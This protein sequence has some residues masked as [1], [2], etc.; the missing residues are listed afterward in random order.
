[1]IHWYPTLWI[2]GCLGKV[3]NNSH[4][5]WLCMCHRVSAPASSQLM[6]APLWSSNL[7]PPNSPKMV[8]WF[9]KF[10]L[11][12]LVPHVSDV[13]SRWEKHV[14][15]RPCISAQAAYSWPPLDLQHQIQ[16]G[17]PPLS[18]MIIRSEPDSLLSQNLT[19]Y[20]PK[21]WSPIALP[22]NAEVLLSFCFQFHYKCSCWRPKSHHFRSIN[23]G[24]DMFE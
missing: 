21:T 5:I 4:R 3:W 17:N 2:D 8:D 9:T 13:F 1:M 18:S 12:G 11:V 10:S 20:Y 7:M 15:A 22:Q 24:N 19:L 16:M 23:L 6:H 14:V